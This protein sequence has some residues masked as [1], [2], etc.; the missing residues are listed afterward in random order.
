MT[1]SSNGLKILVAEDG[2]DLG[3]VRVPWKLNYS[4]STAWAIW[5]Q[6]W[7]LSGKEGIP[8]LAGE[9]SSD[10]HEEPLLLL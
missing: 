10:D 3:T 2:S 4:E 6:N 5:C 1:L 9:I 7:R 8:I